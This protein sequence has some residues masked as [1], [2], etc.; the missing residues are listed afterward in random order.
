VHRKNGKEE[1]KG[2]ESLQPIFSAIQVSLKGLFSFM[3]GMMLMF[4]LQ[5]TSVE[6]IE[7]STT[8]I[9]HNQ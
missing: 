8:P 4:T 7:F 2:K 9:V 5:C 6:T 1:Q 3:H